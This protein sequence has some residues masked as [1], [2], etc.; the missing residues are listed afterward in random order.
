MGRVHGLIRYS[1]LSIII[2]GVLLLAQS[3]EASSSEQLDL[4]NQDAIE[5]VGL[6]SAYG[7]GNDM[8]ISRTT[9]Y[10]SMSRPGLQTL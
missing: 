5:F 10:P 3:R 2:P 8:M 6:V 4:F 7:E 1:V 9:I